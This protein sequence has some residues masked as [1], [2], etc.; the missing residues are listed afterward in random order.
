MHSLTH[1]PAQ[2]Q[3][4]SRVCCVPTT[5]ATKTVGVLRDGTESLLA[6]WEF[7][8]LATASSGGWLASGGMAALREGVVGALAAQTMTAAQ[9]C[10]AG[11]GGP[12]A[13]GEGA[14]PGT[15]AAMWAAAALL[16]SAL[17]IGLAGI[18]Q[19]RSSGGQ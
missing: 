4:T 13:S 17:G 12:A 9:R 2:S 10:V 18:L 19:A 15:A 7:E 16:S 1:S 5:A 14:P 3:S 11:S 6:A 8:S